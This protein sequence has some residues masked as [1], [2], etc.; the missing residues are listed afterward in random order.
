[1]TVLLRIPGFH[2]LSR[3][4]PPP[5]VTLESNFVDVLRDDLGFVGENIL[6]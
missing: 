4:A 2:R 6:Q 5:F 3:M 1:M